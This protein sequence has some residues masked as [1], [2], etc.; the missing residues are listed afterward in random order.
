M[1]SNAAHLSPSLRYLLL[2]VLATVALWASASFSI[3]WQLRGDPVFPD[4]FL[5]P[6]EAWQDPRTPINDGAQTSIPQRSSQV[7]SVGVI[8]EPGTESAFRLGRTLAWPASARYVRFD[9][10]VRTL[11]P[12]PHRKPRDAEDPATR[13]SLVLLRFFD[14]TGERTGQRGLMQLEGETPNHSSTAVYHVPLNTEQIRVEVVGRGYGGQYRLEHAALQA[15]APNP[16]RWLARLIVT[17][18]WCALMVVAARWTRQRVGT[19][20]LLMLVLAGSV[21]VWGVSLNERLGHSALD[22]LLNGPLWQTLGLPDLHRWMLF[23]IGHALAFALTTFIALILFCNDRKGISVAFVMANVAVI[24]VASEALQRHLLDRSA[25]PGDV[26]IDML[27]A[28]LALLTWTV[29][30]RL[31]R[32]W[33]KRRHERVFRKIV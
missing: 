9:A 19:R 31:P 3:Q 6:V 14:A 29:L 16:A 17:M 33:L 23:K 1:I 10:R 4:G 2:L 18:A 24:A 25:E 27:G 12:P 7:D 20:G 15:L 32:T 28:S 11:Q 30:V 13:R 22:A 8:I 5:Q 21:I 26:V